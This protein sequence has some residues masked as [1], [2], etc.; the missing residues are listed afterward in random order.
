[1]AIDKPGYGGYMRKGDERAVWYMVGSR[2]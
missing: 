1:M 2:N